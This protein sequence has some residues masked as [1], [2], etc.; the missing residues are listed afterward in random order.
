MTI[1]I[2]PLAI[3]DVKL[4]VPTRH[5]DARGFVVETWNRAAMR[6]C[7]IAMEICQENISKSISVG[8]VRGLHFQ[9]PPHA[10]VKLLAVVSGRILDVAVDLRKASPTFGAHVAI[11]MDAESGTQIYIP[12]GFAHGYCTLEPNTVVSYMMSSQYAPSHEYGILW[13]DPSLNIA[14]P[15]SEADA[16]VTKRDATWPRLAE[17]QNPF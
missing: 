5:S 11:A 14:W 4:V 3:A 12:E 2:R 9:S 13:A 1:D 8:T 6:T 15:V 10:Q 16:V 17:L 7:G